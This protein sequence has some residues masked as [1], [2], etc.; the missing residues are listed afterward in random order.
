[1]PQRG[2]TAADVVVP[3]AEA[4]TDNAAAWLLLLLQ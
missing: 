2:E 3:A 1:M 4:I